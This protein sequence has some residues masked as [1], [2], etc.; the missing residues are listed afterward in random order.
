MR[1][2]HRD[3]CPVWVLAALW[4]L[5]EPT[6]RQEVVDQ[7]LAHCCRV[8]FWAVGHARGRTPS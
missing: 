8:F 2:G 7:A 5:R 3:W 1:E 4:L 6:A